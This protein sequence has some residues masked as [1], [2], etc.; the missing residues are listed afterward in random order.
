MKEVVVCVIDLKRMK[1]NWRTIKIKLV[2]SI[3]TKSILSIKNRSISSIKNKSVLFI[4]P[5]RT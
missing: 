2:S 5:G 1:T 4:T 3:E